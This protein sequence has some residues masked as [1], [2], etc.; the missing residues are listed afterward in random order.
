MNKLRRRKKCGF[1]RF[2]FYLLCIKKNISPLYYFIIFY[3]FFFFFSYIYAQPLKCVCVLLLKFII[4]FSLFF[5]PIFFKRYETKRFLKRK[6]TT[7]KKNLQ[8]KSR[9]YYHDFI[10]F[11][12]LYFVCVLS[13]LFEKTKQQKNHP[14]VIIYSQ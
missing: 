3:F 11:L 14:H 1:V 2:Y 10:I 9:C 7:E 8:K 4:I 13:L 6:K 12:S 5:N